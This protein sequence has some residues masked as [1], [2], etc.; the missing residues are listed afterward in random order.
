[1]IKLED[2]SEDLTDS[3]DDESTTSTAGGDQPARNHIRK[4][5]KAIDRE[6]FIL[7]FSFFFIVFH[8][9]ELFL[10]VTID[11][12]VYN[13]SY[14]AIIIECIYESMLIMLN[15]SL[16]LGTWYRDRPGLVIWLGGIIPLLIA[17]LA[18]RLYR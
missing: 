16:L 9:I 1:M 17:N 10:G 5:S 4:K 11:K 6:S 12:V 8:L 3:S 2:N 14:V 18:W 15:V 13:L 7:M